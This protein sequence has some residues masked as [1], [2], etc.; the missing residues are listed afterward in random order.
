MQPDDAGPQTTQVH[1]RRRS[2]DDAGPQTTQAHRR[3]RPAAPRRG[4]T[5]RREWC[6]PHG[7]PE[8]ERGRSVAGLR[9]TTTQEAR[10]RRDPVPEWCRASKVSRLHAG[11]EWSL[12][13]EY[14]DRPDT[15]LCPHWTSPVHRYAGRAEYP[16]RRHIANRTGYVLTHALVHIAVARSELYLLLPYSYL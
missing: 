12:R 9:A 10:R 5:E 16:S 3:R 4:T 7:I 11:G 2:T 13:K 8:R 1:R 6:R 14:M 15:I